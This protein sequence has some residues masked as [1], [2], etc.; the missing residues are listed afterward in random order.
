MTTILLIAGII[1]ASAVVIVVALY[2]ARKRT[3]ALQ[4][5]ALSLGLSFSKQADAALLPSL[6]QY[7]L[8]S[9][10]H[11]KKAKNLLNGSVK[12]IDVTIFDY[13]YTI[14]SGKNSHTRSQT[15]ILF[16]SNLLHLPLFTLRP[17]NLFHKIGKA[18]GYQDIDMESHPA[19]SDKYLLRSKDEQA[20]REL[21][22]ENILEYYD[23][24]QGL[25]TEGGGDRILFYR[26]SKKVRP[27]GM[28]SFL[29]EGIQVFSLFQ[30]DK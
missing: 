18:F 8:F 19:F 12:A 5:A 26:A 22:T 23:Q 6:S 9:Q 14:G 28:Q 7:H 1:A 2:Y 30:S 29:E 21:F 3:E 15:V 16:K 27:E 25:S 24:H 13:R 10:G 11:S 17:E 20:C 4:G